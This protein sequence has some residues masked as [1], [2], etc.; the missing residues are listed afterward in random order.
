[1][2]KKKTETDDLF[3]I[4]SGSLSETEEV[5]VAPEATAEKVEEKK[6]APKAELSYAFGITKDPN[7]KKYSIVTIEYD[8]D[9]GY[10]SIIDIEKDVCDDVRFAIVKAENKQRQLLIIGRK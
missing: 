2:A 4:I 10:S 5:S 1:M 9:T 3:D 8:I 6:V 7:F